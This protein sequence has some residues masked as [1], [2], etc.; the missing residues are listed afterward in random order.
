MSKSK[1]KLP[2]VNGIV[3][4]GGDFLKAGTCRVIV[5]TD[6]PMTVLESMRAY[7]G[8][9]IRGKV[10]KSNSS[11]EE[12][13]TKELEE[14]LKSHKTDTPS[15]YKENST[16]I[17]KT[18]KEVFD[19][20]TCK[21]L[22]FK[23]ESDSDNDNDNE[24]DSDREEVKETKSTITKKK[25]ALSAVEVKET[26]NTK[27]K[28]AQSV[29]EAQVEVKETKSTKKKQAPLVEE[30]QVEVKET[31]ST[32]KKQAP[33]V[34]EVVPVHAEVKDS[35]GGKKKPEIVDTDR[36]VKDSKSSKKNLTTK[37]SSKVRIPLSDSEE[38][39]ELLN[40]D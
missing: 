24:S 16:E 17:V 29:E 13:F 25:Q 34:E 31:K 27:S 33:S 20:K 30:A 1:S 28:Q 26:K 36:D 35:K 19:V 3:V 6:E 14:K 21:K 18:L 38:D 9:N 2:M 8:G 11:T 12:L 40:D 10:V 5:S 22:S 7:Y 39:E 32:K 37:L 4:F 15:M 23:K